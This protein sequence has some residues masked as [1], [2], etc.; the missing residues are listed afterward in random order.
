MMIASISLLVFAII[1]AT[2]H[3]LISV[4]NAKSVEA[5]AKIKKKSIITVTVIFLSVALI[6]VSALGSIIV[7]QQS[8]LSKLDNMTAADMIGYDRSNKEIKINVTMIDN[9]KVSL[10]YFR[11]GRAR[12]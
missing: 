12:R 6:A 5:S 1:F 8:Q 9:G 4:K 7:Y 10:S 2:T 11:I 3:I